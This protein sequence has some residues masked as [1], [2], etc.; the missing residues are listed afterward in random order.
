MQGIYTLILV[1]I[2]VFGLL[3]YTGGHRTSKDPLVIAFGLAAGLFMIMPNWQPGFLHTPQGFLKGI[4]A[5]SVSTVIFMA[6][7]V[8]GFIAVLNFSIEEPLSKNLAV[9]AALPTFLLTGVMWWAALAL[10]VIPPPS[11][12]TPPKRE[13]SGIPPQVPPAPA[14]DVRSLRKSRTA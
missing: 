11:S 5:M 6:V 8:L 4:G 9:M 14:L 13:P 1:A 7:M 2:C 3:M 12:A 10:I